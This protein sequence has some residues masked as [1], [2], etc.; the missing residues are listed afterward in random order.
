M[1]SED[2]Q[3]L[4]A[5]RL[6]ATRS[7]NRFRLGREIG[8]ANVAVFDFEYLNPQDGAVFE[9]LHTDSERFLTIVGSI[10]GIRAAR[11]TGVEFVHFRF[12]SQLERNIANELL[13]LS[14]LR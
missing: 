10:M 12:R 3:I 1:F 9:V 13:T 2:S 7:I 8:K 6:K 5:A 11:K 4:E 14:L